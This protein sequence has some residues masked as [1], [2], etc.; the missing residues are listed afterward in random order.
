MIIKLDSASD[1][2]IYE[3]IKKYIK[4]KISLGDLKANNPLPSIRELAIQLLINPN[5]VAR[6]YRELE[7]E[8]F[9]YTRKGKGCY[10][11]EDSTFLVQKERKTMLNQIF[12]K[13][14]E[15]AKHFNITPKE[16]KRTFEHRFGLVLEDKKKEKK[17]E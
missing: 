13:A 2:P 16:I 6:A 9:I 1:I 7:L 10:I 12:D 14:I 4:G 15:E 5:T 8:G 3:Q 11:S 17:N